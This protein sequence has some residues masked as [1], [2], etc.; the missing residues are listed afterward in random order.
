MQYAVLPH[1]PICSFKPFL[2]L[3]F[4]FLFAALGVTVHVINS[5]PLILKK[6]TWM[7]PLVIGV[8]EGW[9]EWVVL[10]PWCRIWCK[11]GM[12]IGKTGPSVSASLSLYL[13]QNPPTPAS[14]GRRRRRRRRRKRGRR[15]YET[16]F[17]TT[18]CWAWLNCCCCCCCCCCCRSNP[19]F[20]FFA[21]VRLP[22][23]VAASSVAPATCGSTRIP[24]TP[25]RENNKRGNWER[26]ERRRRRRR[27]SFM[28][29]GLLTESDPCCT[30]SLHKWEVR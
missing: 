10:M 4:S 8:R 14:T 9:T 2:F 28:I 3:F 25:R 24:S 13:S 17:A 12:F 5:D 19:P 1:L 18:C 6:D 30:P 27:I 23:D 22:N 16:V 7:T 11:G 15:I 21:F 20:S 29:S 26:S